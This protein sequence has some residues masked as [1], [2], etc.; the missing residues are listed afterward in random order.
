MSCRS[1]AVIS[2][3]R[4]VSS[5][6]MVSVQDL[7]LIGRRD[8]ELLAVLRDRAAR[9]HQ[10]L[11]LEDADDLRVAQRLAGVFVLDDLP[12]PLLDRDR[13]HAVAVGAAD[14]AVEEELHLEQSLRSV[15]VV[16]F[17]EAIY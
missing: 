8:L 12:D 9:E 5:T 14:P 3:W 16:V 13:R 6:R 10:P 15:L 2:T 7:A 1:G 11:L 17:C 4:P